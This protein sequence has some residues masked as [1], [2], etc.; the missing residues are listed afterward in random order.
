MHGP[1][2]VRKRNRRQAD[3]PPARSPLRI[4]ARPQHRL[5]CGSLTQV[6]PAESRANRLEASEAGRIQLRQN[7]LQN[8]RRQA[9]E[10]AQ[11][12]ASC[13]HVAVP[14]LGPASAVAVPHVGLRELQLSCAPPLCKPM[15]DETERRVDDGESL[16]TSVSV[17]R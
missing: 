13:Y 6:T 14:P 3:S 2:A 5:L 8:L 15:V 17:G 11:I 4:A 12:V 9:A 10:G 7:F 16:V 1:R